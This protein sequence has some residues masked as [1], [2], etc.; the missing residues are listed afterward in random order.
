VTPLEGAM[1][2]CKCQIVVRSLL[3][4]SGESFSPPIPN[5]VTRYGC[6]LVRSSPLKAQVRRDRRTGIVALVNSV[7]FGL[8]QIV[9]K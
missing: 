1:E 8:Q 2:V 7:L 6:E 5:G 9:A 4:L 3:L